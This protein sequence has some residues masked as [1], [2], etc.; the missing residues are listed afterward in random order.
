MKL[1]TAIGQVDRDPETWYTLTLRMVLKG[2][3]GPD[4]NN[5]SQK[6]LLSWLPP[7]RN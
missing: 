3:A 4:L 6:L 2:R 7:I 5:E 1:K